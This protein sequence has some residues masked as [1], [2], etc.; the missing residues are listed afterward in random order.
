MT[1]GWEVAGFGFGNP[2]VPPTTMIAPHP[3]SACC[4]PYRPRVRIIGKIRPWKAACIHV[5]AE[6]LQ[7]GHCGDASCALDTRYIPKEHVK[8]PASAPSYCD[9][10]DR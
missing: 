7:D 3:W 4:P 10:G 1:N 8:N 5:S 9:A 6:V 2:S